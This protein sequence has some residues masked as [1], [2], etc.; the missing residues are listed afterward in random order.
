M[1]ITEPDVCVITR[2]AMDHESWLGDTLDQIAVEKAGIMR[3]GKPCVVGQ[4]S[5]PESVHQC[6]AEQGAN[7]LLLGKHFAL[8]DGQACYTVNDGSVTTWEDLGE[9]QLP[10][11]SA[12]AALQAMACAGIE[13]SESEFRQVLSETRLPGRMQWLGERILLD[14]AHNPDA[15]D[16]LKSRIQKIKGLTKIHA[17]VGMYRDKDCKAVFEILGGLIHHW[18]LTNLDDPRAASAEALERCLP[19]RGASRAST[20]GKISHAYSCALEATSED[21]LLLVFGSFPVVAGVLNLAGAR[22]S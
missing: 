17:L 14:V 6:A 10:G 22:P 1:N 11:P 9:G 2:I 21:D 7:L 13:V 18:H 20:Y 12:A 19:H 3:G 8:K 5:P 4:E 16:Y 15:A